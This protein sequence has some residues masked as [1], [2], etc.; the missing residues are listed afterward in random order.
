MQKYV[1]SVSPST[2]ISFPNGT[3]LTTPFS[4]EATQWA[5]DSGGFRA[6]RLP[7]QRD[8]TPALDHALEEMGFVEQETIHLDATS[9]PKGANDALRSPSASERVVLQPAWA[10]DESPQVVL[11]ADE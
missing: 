10:A 7:A 6:G 9:L 11:Y 8:T 2:T 1:R 5:N 4:G 3:Q